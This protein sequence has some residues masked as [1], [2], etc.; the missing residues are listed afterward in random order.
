MD[1]KLVYALVLGY[2]I[3][4]I[5][6]S[7]LIVKIFKKADVRDFGSG[8]AGTTNVNR[9]L[10]FWAALSVFLL[11][12]LKGAAAVIIGRWLFGDIGGL[13]AGLGAV[14]GH[15]WPAVL[16]FRGGKGVATSA[17]VAITLSP[18]AFGILLAVF[19]IVV[20][21]SR[22]I[23]LGSILVGIMLPVTLLVFGYPTREILLA[24]ILAAMLLFQHRGNIQ[25]LLTGS[26]NRLN[27][28]KTS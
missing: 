27:L 7:Y 8:N 19:I 26:E 23:S 2:I 3:G 13:I 14:A 20:V 4:N 6:P 11:D 1:I 21:L 17:G 15:N 24:A 5:S 25:R 22:Y 10:G 12:A 16:R 28:A 9:V 18:L